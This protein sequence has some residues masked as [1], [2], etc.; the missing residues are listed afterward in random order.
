VGLWD[1][2]GSSPS[3]GPIRWISDLTGFDT[4][5][6]KV[7]FSP[8]SQ[9]LV[10]GGG[11][12]Y[13]A[14]LQ[15][16][17]APAETFRL[18]VNQ[19]VGA[20]AFSPDGRWLA[21]PS[22]YDARL[23]DLNKPDPSSEPL[24]LPGHKNYIASLAFSPDG[25]WFATGSGDYT[26][27]LW[28][29]A[30]RFTAPA[31]LRGHEGP[32]S[33]LAFSHDSR[34]LATASADRTVRLWQTSSP[35]AEPLALRTPDDSSELHIWDIR[36]VDSLPPPRILG[37][38]LDPGA[39]TVFSPDGQWI[40]TIP[41]GDVDFVHLWNVATPSPTH[42]LVRHEGGIWAS[43]VFSPDGRWLATGGVDDPTIRLWD[44]KTPDPTSNPKELGRHGG[45]VRSLAFSADG[46]R[47]VTGANDGVALVWNSDAADPSASPRSLAGGGGTSIVNT[48]AISR[49][50]RYVVTG[51]WEPDHAARIWDLSAPDSPSNPITLSFEGRLDEVAFST[52]GRWVAAGSWDFTTQLLD[53]TEPD[54]KPFVLRGH[55]ARTLSVAFSPDS[56]W[57]ATGNEDQ[58]ARLWNLAEADPAADSTVLQAGYKVGNVSF[59]PDG[60]WLALSPSEHRSNP[61][62]PD[63]NWFAASSADTRL[64]H[65]R[66]ED[67]IPLACRTAGRNLTNDE[68]ARSFADQPYRKTCPALP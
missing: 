38:R 29:V 52:D 14:V 34:Q 67:L 11:E 7:A 33:A 54:A 31:V 3:N 40:A 55:T 61:F 44:L 63:G 66:L 59:S 16:V 51:S 1:L 26:A 47:L 24:I 17:T 13:F 9:W 36:A 37:E 25:N 6:Y 4:G 49:D 22:Q 42:Y 45:P 18:Q 10:A 20:V 39:G 19:W 5:V 27:Q 60:R 43:P 53:L 68:W 8:D 48:V 21:T 50:G 57:L 32:I 58:T 15:R 30:K 65:L 2:R 62:S 12:S 41:A 64:Y 23:W 46:N 35:A 56:Q 28:N